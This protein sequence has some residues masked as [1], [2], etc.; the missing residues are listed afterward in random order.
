MPAYILGRKKQVLEV[1]WELKKKTR[2]LN[3]KYKI[4]YRTLAEPF[5]NEIL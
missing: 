2:I 5:A 4:R 3:Y 1:F